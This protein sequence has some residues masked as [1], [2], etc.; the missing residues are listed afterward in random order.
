MKIKVAI[1]MIICSIFAFSAIAFAVEIQPTDP[2]QSVYVDF[3]A[4]Q[5][6][7]RHGDNAL[8]NGNFDEAITAYTCALNIEAA[9]PFAYYGR[10]MAHYQQEKYELAIEDLLMALD[11]AGHDPQP[12][13]Y[14]S[15]AMS[16]DAIGETSQALDFYQQYLDLADVPQNWVTGRID[17]INIHNQ[18]TSKN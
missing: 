2:C 4:V 3:E 13:Y 17:E 15:L 10:G 9:Y 1:L 7:T 12:E 14:L 16:Y 6:F 5:Q 18:T 8:E 11:Y